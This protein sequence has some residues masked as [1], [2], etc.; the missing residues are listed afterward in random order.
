M[1][2]AGIESGAD[3][4]ERNPSPGELYVGVVALFGDAGDGQQFS[5]SD[6]NRERLLV[7]VFRGN[8]GAN[9]FDSGGGQKNVP[10]RRRGETRGTGRRGGGNPAMMLE[11]EIFGGDVDL[12]RNHAGLQDVLLRRFEGIG[13]GDQVGGEA[14]REVVARRAGG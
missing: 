9:G 2:V 1:Y 6:G 7:G 13:S 10:A 12:V 3:F 11:H 5:A 4:V 8:E 14:A